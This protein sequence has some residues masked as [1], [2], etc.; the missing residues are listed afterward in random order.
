MK[1]SIFAFV[2]MSSLSFSS[3]A[4]TCTRTGNGYKAVAKCNC[5]QAEAC[6]YAQQAIDAMKY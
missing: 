6:A 1:K 2:I 5:S 4:A 3:F